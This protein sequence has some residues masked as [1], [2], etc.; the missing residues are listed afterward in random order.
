VV[1]VFPEPGH[2]ALELND[3]LAED[4][5]FLVACYSVQLGLMREC[6]DFVLMRHAQ[7]TPYF[8]AGLFVHRGHEFMQYALNHWIRVH[9]RVSE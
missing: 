7:F 9:D 5:N 1:P 4:P 8:N 6:R 3:A 2:F